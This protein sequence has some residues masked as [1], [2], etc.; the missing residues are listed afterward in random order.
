MGTEAELTVGRGEASV[1]HT[2]GM[3]PEGADAV[4]MVERTQKLDDETIEVLRAVAPGENIIE[5]GDD[6]KRGELLLEP[7]HSLRAQDIGGLLAL[8]ILSVSVACRPR[9]AIVATGDEIIP[10][11]EKPG[12]GQVRDVN[13]YTVSG[14]VR[15]AGG[16]ALSRKIVPD[17]FESVLDAARA[18]LAEADVLVISAG[19]SVSVRDLSAS[20]VSELGKPG[21]LVHGISLRPGKPTIIAV[22]SG[23]PVFGL[24]GNPVSAMV[25]SELF[26]CPVLHRLQGVSKAPEKRRVEARLSRHVPSVTGRE[27]YVPVRIVQRGDRIEADPVFGKSNLIYT[28]VKADGLIVVPVDANGLHEGDSVSVRL[29]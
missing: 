26:L 21:I 25:V 16:V 6:V 27:D 24:P 13:T 17:R 15:R 29:F 10:P 9:V 8:G 12:P 5:V 20:V 19:S 11:S 2:G 18:G 7:G 1:A 4:V 23:K 14:L 22:C 28:L 3:V